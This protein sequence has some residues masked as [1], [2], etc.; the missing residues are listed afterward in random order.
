M[1]LKPSERLSQRQI[2][3]GLSL[4]VKE[5]MVTEAMTALM[6]GTFLVA[7]ALLLGASNIQI[8]ILAVLPGF[9]S[10]FQ[11]VA[12]RLLQKYNNRRAIAV[13]C[14]IFAR[15]PLLVIGLLPL[16]F[17]KGTSIQVLI[18]LLFFYYFFGSVNKDDFCF[19]ITLL[20]CSFYLF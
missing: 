20:S 13:V 5:G 1:N 11:L 17:S 4:V 6:G 9:S 14:T 18:F 3:H 16:I 19:Q 12:I 8:G 2:M 10:I 7:L 15:I